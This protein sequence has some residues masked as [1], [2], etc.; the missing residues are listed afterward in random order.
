MIDDEALEG[1]DTM[2]HATVPFL[3][4]NKHIEI[5]RGEIDVS[6]PIN[7]TASTKDTDI[8]P[9][10][11][12][13]AFPAVTCIVVGVQVVHSVQRNERHIHLCLTLQI[14]RTQIA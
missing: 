6:H 5:E 7:L 9:E 2:V 4:I 1:I 8:S 13:G 12:Q 11:G 14:Q 10:R 3:T